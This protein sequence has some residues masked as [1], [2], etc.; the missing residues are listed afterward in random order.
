MGTLHAKSK[1]QYST[2]ELLAE[3]GQLNINSY[4]WDT[5]TLS[6]I[7]AETPTGTLLNTEYTNGDASASP[8]GIVALGHDGSNVRAVKVNSSGNPLVVEVP[9]STCT[10]SQVT[11]VT[12]STSIKAAN[13]S[14]KGISVQNDSD[15]VMFLLAGSGTASS[16]NYTVMMYPDDYWEAP[17]GYTGALTGIW[18]SGVTGV[19]AVAEYT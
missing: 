14:R 4:V 9:A 13:T 7:R 16:S 17:Y 2:D 18:E 5:D 3:D 1:T 19:A 11:A 6:W 8:K 15:R 12:S 10:V